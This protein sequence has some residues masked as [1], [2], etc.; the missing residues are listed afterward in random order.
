[1]LGMGK[2]FS[3]EIINFKSGNRMHGMC[4]PQ[5]GAGLH[6]CRLTVRL[7]PGLVQALAECTYTVPQIVYNM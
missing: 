6:I 3:L 5:C 1:M 7:I 4:N 2:V